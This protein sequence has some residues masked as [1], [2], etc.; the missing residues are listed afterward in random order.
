[1][2][3]GEHLA[4]LNHRRSAPITRISLATLSSQL[5]ILQALLS[6]CR[7]VEIDVWDGE[8][9]TDDDDT[10]SVS[11]SS[12]SSSDD[13]KPADY[14][15]PSRKERLEKKLGKRIV[16]G[17]SDFD[18]ISSKLNRLLSRKSSRP[19]APAASE[20]PTVEPL[21]KI[22]SRPE[23]MVLHGHTLTKGTSFRDVCYA[24]RDSA[25][26]NNDLPVIVSLEVHA[27][28]EQQETMVEI[29][30]QAWEG[31][32]VDITPESEVKKMP[33]LEGLKRKILVKV[34][35][36]PPTGDTDEPLAPTNTLETQP[37]SKDEPSTPGEEPAYKPPKILHAL[38]RLALYTKG[39]HFDHFA[40]PGK[41][42][43]TY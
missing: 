41:P 24:I 25:F 35:W 6:G 12:D 33:A 18:V 29:I 8:P 11:S 13:E 3:A 39:F 10:S 2:I 19:D 34:K 30:E 32:L 42:C 40:Q 43:R 5:I 31:L 38:S 9:D 7:C 23:P 4:S 27:C 21:T 22:P 20:I 15:K 28:L 16:K 36:V 1:M 37:S 17:G 26:V 14:V